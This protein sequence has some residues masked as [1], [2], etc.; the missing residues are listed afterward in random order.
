ML[1]NRN[2]RMQTAHVP[3][4]LHLSLSARRVRASGDTNY[5]WHKG[6]LQTIGYNEFTVVYGI[7]HLAARQT[8]LRGAV[9]LSILSSRFDYV[10]T[11]K[12]AARSVLIVPLRMSS[13]ARRDE[14]LRNFINQRT[15][16]IPLVQE[17]K[18]PSSFQQTCNG[19]AR[20]RDRLLEK[21]SL[22]HVQHC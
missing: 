19:T 14:E 22:H 6:C 4:M 15:R 8:G 9:C 7:W 20:S 3:L 18:A 13:P 11:T 5:L 2:L 10:S 12:A 16:Q 17:S 21:Y 1:I